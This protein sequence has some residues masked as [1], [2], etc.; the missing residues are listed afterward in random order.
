MKTEV[1][2]FNVSSPLPKCGGSS[3]EDNPLRFL[4]AQGAFLGDHPQS[5][6][7]NPV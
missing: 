3:L 6:S 2:R 4:D 1:F 7:L 5:R